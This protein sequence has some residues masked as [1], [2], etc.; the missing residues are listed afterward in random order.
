M[1]DEAKTLNEIIKFYNYININKPKLNGDIMNRLRNSLL[2]TTALVFLISQIT[3]AKGE[4]TLTF[5]PAVNQN[6]ECQALITLEENQQ[7]LIKEIAN[8]AQNKALVQGISGETTAA[9]SAADALSNALSGNYRAAAFDAA[10]AIFSYAYGKSRL[11]KASGLKKAKV[12][13]LQA[14]TMILNDLKNNVISCNS[15]P[16]NA[17]YQNALNELLIMNQAAIEIADKIVDE[18]RSD[19]TTYLT[20]SGVSLAFGAYILYNY[21][22]I[23]DIRGLV[24]IVIGGSVSIGGGVL[25]IATIGSQISLSKITEKRAELVKAN[26]KLEQM[27]S[28]T[29][30]QL[31]QTTSQP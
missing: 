28:L 19:R 13:M 3:V 10:S 16:A 4:N 11:E 22:K 17:L 2:K 9:F 1:I 7:R 6:P 25:A 18:Y 26:E 8:K 31:N 27:K 21:S 5:T 30:S 14:R 12:S 29:P 23:Q 20:F 24:A 15:G